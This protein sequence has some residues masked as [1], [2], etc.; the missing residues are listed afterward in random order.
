MKD[1]M[2]RRFAHTLLIFLLMCQLLCGCSIL[3]KTLTWVEE[4]GTVI[5]QQ[6]VTVFSK[7]VPEKELPQDTDKWVYT[8]W[9]EVD[10][11]NTIVA[12]RTPNP[13]F[14]KGN[15]FQILTEDLGERPIATGTGYVFS[16]DGWFI[17]NA[18]VMSDCYYAY[19]VFNIRDEKKGE[20]FIKLPIEQA[21]FIDKAKDIFIGKIKNYL[22]SV[23]EHFKEFSMSTEHEIG[24]VTYSIGFPNSSIKIEC[25]KGLIIEDY[26]E[27]YDKLYTGI[28]YVGSSSFVAPGSSGGILIDSSF[29]IIG[30]TTLGKYDS[31]DRFK[32]G[33]AIDIFNYKDYMTT[34]GKLNSLPI[35]LHPDEKAFLG[36][37]L[38]NVK[39][40]D[41][42]NLRD[43]HVLSVRE[44]QDDYVAYV[45]EYSTEGKNSDGDDYV[46]TEKFVITSNY[47]ISS[48]T[49]YYWSSGDHDYFVLY[50]FYS[51]VNELKDFIYEENYSWSSGESVGVRCDDINY[52]ENVLLTLNRL[53]VISGN[54]STENLTYFKGHFNLTYKYLLGY[55]DDFR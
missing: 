1:A 53:Q 49:E 50:G 17:T 35:F 51:P 26:S 9:K 8:G 12:Q 11:E 45:S 21:S 7:D 38:D 32:Y 55:L 37:Y 48:S 36:L 31:Y 52:S 5:D 22:T 2:F 29:S 3:T 33:A 30:M 27:L 24:D 28:S 16:K 41:K 4:D 15:V 47:F 6:Q 14:F 19:A 46:Y 23:S 34:S 25:N 13:E 43:G 42:N 54:P 39:D 44:E 40:A 10:D 18:H 20:S